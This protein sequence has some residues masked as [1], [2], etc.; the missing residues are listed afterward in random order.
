MKMII[1]VIRNQ[2]DTME[3][4]K[5]AHAGDYLNTK[6]I[7]LCV[8]GGI[9][10]IETPKL[11]RAL[12]RYGA[13]VRAYM[14]PESK[15]FVGEAALE[16]GTEQNV[17]TSLSGRAEH[18]CREDLVL[19]CPST[20]N[21]ISKIAAGI[22]DN[23]VTTLVASALGNRTP[24]YVSPTMH[25]SLYEN[26]AFQENLKKVQAYGGHVIE[27]RAGEGKRKIPA[28]DA[29]V[30]QVCRELS[31]YSIKGRKVLVTGGPTPVKIDSVRLITN[32]FRGK[33]A[34]EIARE[35]YLR[36]AD[37]TL[38]LGAMG[39]TPPSYLTTIVHNDFDEYLMNVTTQ[40]ARGQDV[41]IFA[42][43][44]A[45]YRPTTVYDGKIPSHGALK[46]LHFMETPKVI[47][48]V[49]Q[50]HP[51]LYMVTFKLE[52]GISKE[53]LLAIAHNRLTDGY[54]LVVANRSEDMLQGHTAYIVGADGVVEAHSKRE[55]AQKLVA[56]VG[57]QPRESKY[58]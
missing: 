15:K 12:R 32:R 22:A 56:I 38:L 29:I 34:S 8:T 7:A 53:E 13:T 20:L 41:G 54:Q 28:L 31:T 44:V 3:D 2:G 40:L 4:R 25:D 24:V 16:W 52:A 48:Q 43:A 6:T 14:T 46:E 30:A 47:K 26:P 55:I 37:V 1:E 18:I 42:A 49:R 57:K 9:A 51:D 23:P 45:D 19:V 21:T 58:I 50:D 36:G 39:T 17:V 11:A 33:L 35:A 5:V 27:P 10:A